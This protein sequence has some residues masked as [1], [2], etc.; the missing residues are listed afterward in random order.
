M[1]LIS[2]GARRYGRILQRIRNDI[3]PSS[4]HKVTTALS[5]VAFADRPLK[6]YELLDGIA[7]STWPHRI[8]ASTWLPQQALERYK[9]LI[10]FEMD[11]VVTFIH[12]SVREYALINLCFDFFAD[13]H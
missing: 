11:G 7:L 8:D 5:W 10:E 4:F 2:D 12:S 1:T 3:P 6:T 13:E 9:P